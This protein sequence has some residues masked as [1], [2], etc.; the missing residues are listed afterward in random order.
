MPPTG[1]A[2]SQVPQFAR[3]LVRFAQLLVQ[4]VLPLGQLHT[5]FEHM[6]PAR[7]AWPQVPQLAASVCLSTHTKLHKSGLP[8]GQVH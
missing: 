3:S 7:Q 1:H 2:W 8:D 4:V 5:P 6:S